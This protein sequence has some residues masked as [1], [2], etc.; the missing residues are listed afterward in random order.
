M[1]A[2]VLAHLCS[3]APLARAATRAGA[4]PPLL[5]AVVGQDTQLQAWAL[6][7]LANLASETDN[8]GVLFPYR[9]RVIDSD[10]LGWGS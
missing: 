1:A 3:H 2:G 7:T 8:H 9:L 5:A 6:L 10:R 4:V